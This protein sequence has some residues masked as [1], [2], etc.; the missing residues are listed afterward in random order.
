MKI[1]FCLDILWLSLFNNMDQSHERTFL[2]SFTF[3]VY[4]IHCSTC[5]NELS[6]CAFVVTLEPYI[7]TMTNLDLKCIESLHLGVKLILY[8]LGGGRRIIEK[9]ISHCLVLLN[10]VWCYFWW[11]HL[12]NDDFIKYLMTPLCLCYDKL[13]LR[14]A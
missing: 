8:Q 4:K 5:H 9:L 14:K 12:L 13:L 3:L 6:G 10:L 2:E 11:S 1:N 7:P